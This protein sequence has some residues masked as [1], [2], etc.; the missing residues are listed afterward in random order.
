MVNASAELLVAVAA[1]LERRAAELVESQLAVLR[2]HPDYRRVP[3]DDLRR[4]CHRNVVRVVATLGRTDLL[5]GVEEDE[6]ASGQRRALQ[7]VPSDAVV[8]AYRA[9][10]AVLRD[11]FVEEATATGADT[12]TVLAGTTRLWDLTDRFS[13]VLVSARQQVE[14]DAA[15][16]DERYRIALLQR[17]LTGG[18]DPAE[19]VSGGA[20]H[21]ILPG[22]RYWVVRARD[23]QPGEDT[24]RVARHLEHG[25]GE[26]RTPLVAP[27]DDDIVGITTTPPRELAGTVIAVAG[28]VDL[29]G[30]PAAF[31][32]A[33]RVLTVAVRYGRTGLV[34]SSSLSVRVAVEQQVELGELLHR[35]YLSHLVDGRAGH[36]DVL[37]TVTA[38]LR[39]R[40]SVAATARELSVH[41]NTVRYRLAR[42]TELTG[43]DLADTDV[44]VEVWWALE[45]A[46]IRPT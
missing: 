35:R 13:S 42:F 45:Y 1:R 9:V 28:P 22:S 32:E 46:S 39:L 3:E 38:W 24:Q 33:T 2:E 16:R 25:S 23:Q 34:D 44:L 17:L 12:A 14:I 15:R 4:S 18:L 29:G 7:G 27:V 37:G 20:V 10:L 41:E 26:R 8:Q 11:A 40:R 36:S 21:G 6:R 43:A 19:L 5:P 31:T 30:V